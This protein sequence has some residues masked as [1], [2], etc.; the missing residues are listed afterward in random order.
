MDMRAVLP[1]WGSLV[2]TPPKRIAHRVTAATPELSGA[3]CRSMH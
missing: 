1:S 3:N 2:R